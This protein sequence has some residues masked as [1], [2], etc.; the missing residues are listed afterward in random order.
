M[1]SVP[2]AVV[3]VLV[4]EELLVP[5]VLHVQGPLGVA[6]ELVLVGAAAAQTAVVQRQT[7]ALTVC[8][9]LKQKTTD[10]NLKQEIQTRNKISDSV[11]ESLFLLYLNIWKTIRLDLFHHP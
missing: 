2:A 3:L 6:G 10:A 7:V 1:S 9:E 5:G 4:V 8:C 11:K